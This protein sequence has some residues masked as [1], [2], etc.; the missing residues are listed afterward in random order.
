MGGC[1]RS[2]RMR[3]C[4][5]LLHAVTM[6][7]AIGTTERF[8]WIGVAF[9]LHAKATEPPPYQCV[10]RAFV[11]SAQLDFALPNKKSMCTD[12]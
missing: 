12:L 6:P 8:L 5:R 2:A 11:A 1:A 7:A 3:P 9:L 4:D 10:Q